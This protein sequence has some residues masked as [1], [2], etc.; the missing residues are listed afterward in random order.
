MSREDTN[1]LTLVLVLSA[2]DAVFTAAPR[3][4][5]AVTRV[6]GRDVAIGG[7]LAR[8]GAVGAAGPAASEVSPFATLLMIAFVGGIAIPTLRR[9]SRRM[10]VVAHDVR[11]FRERMYSN[12]RRE[13]ANALPRLPGLDLS[14]DEVTEPEGPTRPVD[15]ASPP[16]QAHPD[17]GGRHRRRLRLVI[18]GRKQGRAVSR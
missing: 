14:N 10:R 2:C 8:E 3:V 15:P 11:V 12:A 1:L 6:S 17:D 4:V 13:M 7:F 16:A 9:A 18:R 5:G